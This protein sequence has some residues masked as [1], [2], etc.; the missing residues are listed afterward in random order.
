LN[1]RALNGFVGSFIAKAN[2]S[3]TVSGITFLSL[4]LTGEI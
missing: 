2:R 3:L 4:G 1:R